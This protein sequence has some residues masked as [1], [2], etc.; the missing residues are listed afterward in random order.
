MFEEFLE[1]DSE[2]ILLKVKGEINGG[3]QDVIEIE[4]KTLEHL[5]ILLEDTKFF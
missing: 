1:T 2:N 5:V 4:E 3:F